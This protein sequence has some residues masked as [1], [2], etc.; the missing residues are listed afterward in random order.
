MI[1]TK[2]FCR[3]R[4]YLFINGP[5]ATVSSSK[6]QIYVRYARKKTKEVVSLIDVHLNARGDLQQKWNAFVVQ[7]NSAD[8]FQFVFTGLL[9]DNA[10][11]MAVD[12]I[13]YSTNCLPSKVNRAT[14]TVLPPVTVTSHPPTLTTQGPSKYH[15]KPADSTKGLSSL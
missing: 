14:T 1:T 10:T 2:G 6:L 4:F 5:P 15:Q 13:T 9:A 12:D 8:P 11:A 7:F 3:L